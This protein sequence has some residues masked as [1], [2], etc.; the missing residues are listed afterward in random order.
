MANE[1]P[2]S[3][4]L[5][6]MFGKAAAPTPA[7][8]PVPAPSAPVAEK[9]QPAVT[10]PP[11]NNEIDYDSEAVRANVREAIDRLNEQM[12]EAGRDLSFGMDESVGRT[13]ITV[14]SSESGELVRQIPEEVVL[15]VSRHIEELKGILYER[16]M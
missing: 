8:A 13:V 2:S 3:T 7:P 10:N 15:N 1:I 11:L 4:M 9:V 12:R 14:R 5:N 6:S 16:L